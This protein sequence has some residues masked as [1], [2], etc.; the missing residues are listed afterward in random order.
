MSGWI[1]FGTVTLVILHVHI[2]VKST[3]FPKKMTSFSQK[4]FL[5]LGFRV[6]GLGVVFKVFFPG[7]W[8]LGKN[9]H[10]WG[11]SGRHVAYLPKI[12]TTLI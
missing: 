4:I 12:H 11:E 9:G 8:G 6:L 1:I 10:F 3:F 5:V 7:L 2:Y